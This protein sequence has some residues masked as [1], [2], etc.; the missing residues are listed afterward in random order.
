MQDISAGTRN[1]VSF[2]ASGTNRDSLAHQI[3]LV[4]VGV[5]SGILSGKQGC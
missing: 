2:H 4:F 3:G 1:T 5:S